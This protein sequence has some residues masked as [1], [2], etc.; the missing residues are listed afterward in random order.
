MI[1]GAVPPHVHDNVAFTFDSTLRYGCTVG[2]TEWVLLGLEPVSKI[3][4][5]DRFVYV[6]SN[7]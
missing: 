7:N 5:N 2:N 6:G 3:H 1:G 4:L